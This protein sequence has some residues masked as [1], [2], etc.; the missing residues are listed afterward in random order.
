MLTSTSYYRFY[1]FCSFTVLAT[2]CINKLNRS[3]KIDSNPLHIQHGLQGSLNKANHWFSLNKMVPNAKKTKQLLLGTKQKL[4]YCADPSL[5]LSLQ[6]TEIEETVNEKLL[7]VKIDK[8]LNWNSHIDYM[9]T[10]LISRVNLLKRA[11]K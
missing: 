10:K 9:I 7:G 4:S 11:R 2:L 3:S 8:H 1:N 5:N 6:G